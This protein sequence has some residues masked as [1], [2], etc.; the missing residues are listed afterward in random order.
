MILAT[1]R[2]CFEEGHTETACPED[3]RDFDLV[4][5]IASFLAARLNY[6]VPGS[7]GGPRA[8]KLV[9]TIR[10][11]QHKEK[12]WYARVYCELA[13]PSLV[14]DEW[15]NDST[16]VMGPPPDDFRQRCFDR[17]AFHYR[18]VHLDMLA[19]LPER[20]HKRVVGFA[21][22]REL[23]FPTAIEMERHVDRLS[24]RD[25]VDPG[26]DNL[27]FYRDRYRVGTNQELKGAIATYYEW[28][29]YPR[30]A[31]LGLTFV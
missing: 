14:E 3:K 25:L 16:F 26:T 5:P 4:G 22:Y 1:C 27:L 17:D 13:A 6:V 15:V 7:N 21:D 20:L 30:L 8:K 24:N 9:S 31:K 29:S 2:A 18:R 12:F 19:L 23:L 11:D 28:P 10:V